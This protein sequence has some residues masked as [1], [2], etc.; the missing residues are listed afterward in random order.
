MA[1]IRSVIDKIVASK[2][3]KQWDEDVVYLDSLAEKMLTDNSFNEIIECAS[4]DE[5]N[6]IIDIIIRN[7]FSSNIVQSILIDVC[8]DLAVSGGQAISNIAGN[9][10]MLYRTTNSDVSIESIKKLVKKLYGIDFDTESFVEGMQYEVWKEFDVSFGL[11]V[12]YRNDQHNKQRP[13]PDVIDIII[14]A[15]QAAITDGMGDSDKI[16]DSLV[17]L[18]TL[19]SNS[20]PDIRNALLIR[21]PS[22]IDDLPCAM[23]M[24]DHDESKNEMIKKTIERVSNKLFK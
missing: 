8:P 20:T 19:W 15:A 23:G 10:K 11:F 2:L 21:R 17:K 6:S 4:C 22:S 24:Y 13:P 5:F 12:E 14:A 3:K 16:H 18:E 7:V 9:L 1:R